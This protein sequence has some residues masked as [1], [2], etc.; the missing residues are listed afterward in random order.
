MRTRTL[1][2]LLFALI[3]PLTFLDIPTKASAQQPQTSASLQDSKAKIK[4][5]LSDSTLWGDDFKALLASI[6]D[7]G[8]SGETKIEAFANEAVGATPQADIA[9][10]LTQAAIF[11][12]RMKDAKRSFPQFEASMQIG[13]TDA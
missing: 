8:E 9:H 13:A 12:G 11:H 6:K 10:A 1:A 7:W 2:L 3:T 4:D 5:I